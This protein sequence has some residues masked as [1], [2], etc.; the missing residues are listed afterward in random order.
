MILFLLVFAMALYAV[1]KYSL[2]HGLDGVSLKTHLG[3]NVVEP[4]EPFSWT[5]SVLNKKRMMVPYLRVKELAP[6]DLVYAGSG[7]S[8]LDKKSAEAN[9]VL[10]LAGRQRTEVTRDVTLPKRGRYFFRGA[11]VEAGDF[12]GLKTRTKSYAELEEIVVKPTPC[13]AGE[14]SLLLGGFLGEYSVRNSLLEDPVLSIGFREYTGREPFRSI[15]WTQSAKY[16]RLL[17]KQYECTADLTCQ[18]LLNMD[19]GRTYIEGEDAKTAELMERCFS[20]VRSVCEELERRKIPYGFLNNGIIAGAVGHWKQVEDG[21]GTAHLETVLE[22]LGR[23]THEHQESMEEFIQK[24]RKGVH[25]TESFVI[26]T[27]VREPRIEALVQ[28]LEDRCGNKV[29]FLC[30]D[31]MEG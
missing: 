20:M 2:E 5:V 26:V 8:V 24:V 10:Y 15:S 19:H 17:V 11:S 22:G 6:E 16:G 4:G 29:L 7:V 13:P 30:A 1:Q 25:G 9:S 14:L 31:E 18:I 3:K 12:L 28:S 21:L 23:M 27:P